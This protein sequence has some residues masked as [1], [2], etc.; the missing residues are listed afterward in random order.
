MAQNKKYHYV[1]RFYLKRLS[2]D[3]KS[4]NLWNLPNRREVLNAN[5]K[6]QCYRNY[7]Y[8]KEREVETALGEVEGDVARLFQVIV[9]P[10]QQMICSQIST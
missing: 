10:L 1:P 6:N 8:G 7:F 3:G 5:L 2:S 9:L 4:I